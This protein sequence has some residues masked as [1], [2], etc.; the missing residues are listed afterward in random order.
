MSKKK[1][2]PFWKTPVKD[3]GV[4]NFLK[5]KGA[6]IGGDLVSNITDVVLRGESP[7]KAVADVIRGNGGDKLSKQDVAKAMELA[8]QDAERLRIERDL[9]EKEIE[10]TGDAR[11]TEIERM[12]S[13]KA[14]WITRNATT[15]LSIFICVGAMSLTTALIFVDDISQQAAPL[16]NV[17][18]GAIFSLLAGMGG[19]YYGRNHNDDEKEINNGF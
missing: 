13:P 8:Q 1:S 15:L 2:K 10:D 4:V 18:F 7:I 5:G 12:R 9:F 14:A 17:A 19:Y 6:D 11:D 16:I 3:W